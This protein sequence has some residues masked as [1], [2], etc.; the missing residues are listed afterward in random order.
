MVEMFRRSQRFYDAIY[1]WKDYRTEVDRLL[2]IIRDRVPEARTL[3]DVACGTG[4]HLE[5]LG[6]H[7][8]VEG[9]DVDP[10]MIAIAGERLGEAVPLHVADMTDLEL[11]RRFDVVTCLFSSIAYVRT[12]DRLD[13]AVSSLAR[14]SAPGGLVIVEPWFFPEAW[15][16]EHVDARFV[17][18]EN[19]KIARMTVSGPLTDPLT[20]RFHYLVATPAGVEHFTE[21]HIV[22]MFTHE[23]YVAAFEAAGLAVEHDPEGLMGRGLYVGRRA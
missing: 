17:D 6:G 12:P 14:H 19:L 22:G 1:A 5:L 18:E 3:L 21:D 16:P 20:M 15:T 23:A 7:F 11:G 8:R 2:S 9:V 10:E 4:K 13:R